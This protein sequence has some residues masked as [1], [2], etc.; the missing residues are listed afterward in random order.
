MGFIRRSVGFISFFLIP[1]SLLAETDLES[2]L[3]EMV[4]I[5]T[6]QFKMGCV[7]GI[8]CKPRE[9]PVHNVRISSFQMAKTE[10]TT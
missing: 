2:L 5:P 9:K 4:D 7:S 1:F 3:P 10:V 8:D 6:G